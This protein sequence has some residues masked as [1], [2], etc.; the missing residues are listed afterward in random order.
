MK[1][2][3]FYINTIARGGGAE[4]VISQL[5]NSFSKLQYEVWLLTSEM[6]K[7]EYPICSEVKRVV[8]EER[9]EQS[10]LK[11]NLYRVF[12]LRTF[13]KENN[14]ELLVS[15]MAEPNIRAI[16]ATRL[17]NTK[18]IVSVRNDPTKEYGGFFGKQIMKYVMPL[19]NGCVFQTDDAMRAFPQKLQNKSIVIMNDVAEI[20]FDVDRCVDKGNIVTIGRLSAQKNHLF[21]IQA[22]EEVLKEHP[23]YKLNIYGEGDLRESLE[24]YINDRNLDD[25]IKL[26][27][28][29]E[30]VVSVLKKAEIFVLPSLYEG[31]PNALLEAMAVGV[32]SVSTDCPCGGPRM[33]IENMKN[34]ILVPVN[35]KKNLIEAINCLIENDE[36]RSVISKNARL[37]ANE[38]KP[39]IVFENWRKYIDSYLV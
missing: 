15:F 7:I 34:G 11:R 37:C 23:S 28:K 18:C 9:K 24:T 31:M 22:F 30:D 8:L 16:L 12:K 38:Y 2:I 20:F 35:E 32:P 36:L 21:L 4:R 27:G 29:T 19:A 26:N 3:A 5:V 1:K 39:D 33:L 10:F 14:I 13:C 17:I 25:Y 6:R